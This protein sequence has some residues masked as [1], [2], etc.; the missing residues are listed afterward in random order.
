MK[1]SRSLISIEV[2]YLIETLK[3]ASVTRDFGTFKKI[4]NPYFDLDLSEFYPEERAFLSYFLGYFYVH[5]GKTNNK[6]DF[7]EK[8][9]DYLTNAIDHFY[10]L[11]LTDEAIEA[12]I[13]LG[14]A[15]F[16]LGLIDNYEAY[17]LDA[18]SEC[19]ENTDG[20]FSV[21]VSLLIVYYKDNRIG[22]GLK[23]I[24]EIENEIVKCKSLR[25]L[26]QFYTNAGLIYQ[27]AKNYRQAV[28][29]YEE[30][31]ETAHRLKNRQFEAMSLNCLGYCYLFAEKYDLALWNVD[32]S[33]RILGELSDFGHYAE[34]LDTK[35]LIYFEIGEV[36]E[37]LD[38]I[39]LAL[40]YFRQG[41][42]YRAWTE[43]LWNKIKI[44]QR[45]EDSVGIFETFR[46][47]SDLTGKTDLDMQREYY[48]KFQQICLIPLGKN[49]K[50][51]TDFCR[52]AIIK[53]ALSQSK[54]KAEAAEKLGEKSHHN[55]SNFLKK[56]KMPEQTE[57]RVW[58]FSV[59]EYS[60]N[61]L[62]K[63]GE[64]MTYQ[65][66]RDVSQ[67]FFGAD[68]NVVFITVKADSGQSGEL[69]LLAKEKTSELFLG[70][71][72]ESG[73]RFYFEVE[74]GG[75]IISGFRI[76]GRVVYFGEI[77]KARNEIKFK[78]L[79]D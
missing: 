40:S 76:L 14:Y 2:G 79:N 19:K 37:S 29:C 5:L 18:L 9:K 8:G 71:L 68:S 72:V 38:T 77:N 41:E 67:T 42:N 66:S 51:K 55:I 62:Q 24:R 26:S 25:I 3:T 13:T 65:C 28:R 15:D 61:I 36:K 10:S 78:R 50:E 21:C 56:R 45:L 58:K 48:R 31:I 23:L 39:N 20:Y 73:N 12:K 32:E 53:S 63:R 35:A 44:Q 33:L 34:V 60:V 43:S 57:R 6:K 27:F 16:Q 69:F 17:L 74:N 30:A 54:T 52:E 47:L 22:E 11:N 46:E 64:L 75:A 7:Q 70:E 1:D 4:L 59:D 49:L